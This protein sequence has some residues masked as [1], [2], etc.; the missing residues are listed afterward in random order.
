M[1]SDAEAV[2]A[3]FS[4]DDL[5]EHH[6]DEFI[7]E[8]YGRIQMRL[9][10]SPDQEIPLKFNANTLILPEMM[11]TIAS[12]S[13][14]TWERTSEL[15][16]DGNDDIILSWNRGGYRFTVPGRGDFET[17][18]GTAAILPLDRRF[19]I[20]TADSRWTMALQFKRA[21]LAPLVRN[22]DD[23]RLDGIGRDHPAHRLLF[24]YLWSVLH[25][26]RQSPARMT[27]L[28]AR[29]VADILALSF[30]S[31]RPE[32][33][34]PGIR[35]AR[36][37]AIKQH[38]ARNLHDPR[39]NAEQ[40]ARRFG[41]SARYVRQLF[42]DEQTSFSDYVT[43]QRLASV[44]TCLTDRRQV[45][46]RVADIAFETGFTEPSTFYRQFRLRYGMT[47]TEVRLR[48]ATGEG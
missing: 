13:P 21:L 10:V 19:S 30:G 4:A 1:L 9:Q 36:L 32:E 27:P 38:I 16:A 42:A 23:M 11:C 12:V 44:H 18:P 5:P 24:D 39:L 45:L 35:A 37:A 20:S 3:S 41:I 28:I 6:R 31:I 17:R 26:G 22:L 40:A 29:H 47:P 46:R 48:A 7:R 15:M 2:T 34:L 14:M 33:A 43:E 25:M 8:F